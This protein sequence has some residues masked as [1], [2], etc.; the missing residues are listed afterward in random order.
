MA[1]PPSGPIGNSPRD[2]RDDFVGAPPDVIKAGEPLKKTRGPVRVKSNTFHSKVSGG[3]APKRADRARAPT[4]RRGGWV[5]GYASGGFVVKPRAP[6]VKEHKERNTRSRIADAIEDKR[7]DMP[8]VQKN[9]TSSNQNLRGKPVKFEDKPVFTPSTLRRKAKLADGGEVPLRPIDA[10]APG[11]P[12]QRGHDAVKKKF[13]DGGVTEDDRERGKRILGAGM[14]ASQG[15]FTSI[16]R[17]LQLEDEYGKARK[18]AGLEG[19]ADGGGLKED[20]IPPDDW[21]RLGPEPP[22]SPPRE[23]RKPGFLE[24]QL[25]KGRAV[26]GPKRPDRLQ[27]GGSVF[28]LETPEERGRREGRKII[29][30]MPFNAKQRSESTERAG[31]TQ[32][33]GRDFDTR[34]STGKYDR[35]YDEVGDDLDI[36]TRAGE[37]ARGG[38]VGKV[39]HEFKHGEL[40]SGS[41]KGPVVKSRPQAIAIGLSEARKAGESV[42]RKRK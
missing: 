28:P 3:T 35:S 5:S 11:V 20:R 16:R 17:N 37:Y 10:K 8:G 9:D 13:A 33:L 41:S 39:M 27:G 15:P 42:P 19:K 18:A 24:Q 40:H 22:P 25:E 1:R 23:E 29:K 21:R 34:M 38:K 12:G 7:E 2:V 6:E 26:F 30:E 4:F 14:T 31:A 32:R 36:R